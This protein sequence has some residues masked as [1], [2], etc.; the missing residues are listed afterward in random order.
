MYDVY[1]ENVNSA[2]SG[3][4]EPG[5]EYFCHFMYSRYRD[6]E[7]LAGMSQMLLP[8]VSPTEFFERAHRL[9]EKSPWINA[10]ACQEIHLFFSMLAPEYLCPQGQAAFKGLLLQDIAPSG[11]MESLLIFFSVVLV[12][13]HGGV[14]F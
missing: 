8:K 11:K 13:G 6:I 3:Q 12:E 2:S 14:L 5:A 9:F 1:V 10:P 4:A 7:S